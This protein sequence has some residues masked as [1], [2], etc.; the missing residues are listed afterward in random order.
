MKN[1]SLFDFIEAIDNDRPT[2]GG[3][4]V[5]PYAGALSVALLRMGGHITFK[6]ESFLSQPDERKV[7]YLHSF[8][9]LKEIEIDLL[10]LMNEDSSAYQMVMTAIKLPKDD[11]LRKQTLKRTLILAFDVP[12]R[13]TELL[14]ESFSLFQVLD[15]VIEGAVRSDVYVAYA[16]LKAALVGASVTMKAN[17]TPLTKEDLQPR[18]D[19]LKAK[20]LEVTSLIDGITR[21]EIE[22]D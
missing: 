7:S 1:R 11:P 19:I 6:K 5:A 20:T 14:I 2:P 4:A 15:P 18:W 22:G 16:L 8:S 13:I 10:Q 12:S 9:R 3:G 21:R 17:I